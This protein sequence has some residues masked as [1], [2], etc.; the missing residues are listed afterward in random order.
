MTAAAEPPAK[1]PSSEAA[2]PETPVEAPKTQGRVFLVVVDE[3]P[4]LKVALLYACRRAQKTGG[5]VALLHVAETGDFQQFFGVG[6]VMAQETRQ[7]AEALMQKMAAEVFRLSDTMP[8]LYLREGDRRDELIKLINEEP[9]I[10][11]LVLG[12]STTSKG[13]GPLVSALTGKFVGK[14]RVPL[15]IVPGNLSDQDI[16]SIS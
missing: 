15:T 9:S 14:L 2:P 16:Q 3:S 8:V 4:E 1:P 6:K 7:A 11:I 5:R 13:P 10:S 12:A